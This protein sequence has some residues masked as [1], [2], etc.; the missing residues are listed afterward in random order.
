MQPQTARKT[1][2]FPELDSSK[3]PKRS[4]QKYHFKIKVMLLCTRQKAFGTVFMGRNG[5]FSGSQTVLFF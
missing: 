1:Y 4:T 3:G 5:A 2:L